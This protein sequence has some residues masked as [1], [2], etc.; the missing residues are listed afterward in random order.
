MNN[1]QELRICRCGNEIE[2]DGELCV[3][4]SRQEFD[5]ELIQRIAKHLVGTE[6]EREQKA[7][8]IKRYLNEPSGEK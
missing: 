3:D 2:E 7:R 6:E 1:N 4:C 8:I 5:E